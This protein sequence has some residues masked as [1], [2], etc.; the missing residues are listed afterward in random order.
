MQGIQ[1][2]GY[3]WIAFYV[4]WIAWAFQSKKTQQR[5]S[6]REQ[7]PYRVL[8]L[9]ALFLMF[10]PAW[11]IGWLSWLFSSI[12]PGWIWLGWA[13]VTITAAGFA[14]S[15]WARSCLGDNWSSAPG[16]KV[17]HQLIRS[18][19]YRWVRH[20]IYTGLILA[21]AGTALARNQW[22]GVIAVVMMWA[23][24]AIKSQREEH[25]MRQT[26]GSQYR[27]Y[28]QTTGRLTPRLRF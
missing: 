2:C 26:F 21:L 4:L 10:T 1:I 15:I 3:L 19:P 8:P 16:V 22:R 23:A 24:F 20:P 28:S 11:G 25:Y 17:E 5:D 18:G 9:A 7:L 12:A 27:E 13:G 14:I 6:S